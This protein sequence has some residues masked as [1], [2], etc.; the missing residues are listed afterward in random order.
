MA[1]RVVISQRAERDLQDIAAW[2]ARERSP[3]QASRWLTGIYEK[4]RTLRD[5]AAQWP[6]APESQDF[7]IELRELHYGTG[8]RATHRA[9]YT[10]TEDLVLILTVRHLAQDRL[11]ADEVLP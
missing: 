1:S 6:L 9:V 4:L 11:A 7:V 3:E 8:R 2:W 5:S 10:V